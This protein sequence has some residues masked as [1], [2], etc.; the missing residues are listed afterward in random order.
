MASAQVYTNVKLVMDALGLPGDE[1]GLLER[2]REASAHIQ[3]V[4]GAFIPVTGSKNFIGDFDPNSLYGYAFLLDPLIAMTAIT[5]ANGNS[6]PSDSYKFHPVNRAWENG[7]YLRLESNYDEHNLSGRWGLYEEWISSGLSGTL[8]SSSATSLSL[9]NGGILWPGCVIKLES[10]QCLVTAGQG[11]ENSPSPTTA[12]ATV[13]NSLD[14]TDEVI[15]VTNGAEFSG[16]EVIRIDHEDMLIRRIATND[17]IVQRGW[18]NTQRAAHLLAA[19]ISVYRTVTIERGVNG[20]T[21]AAHTSAAISLAKIPTDVAALATQI[22]ALLRGKAQT[23]YTGR[24]GNAEA[25]ESFW[26]NE[27]PRGPIKAVKEAYSW[28]A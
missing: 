12:T 21:A 25:G 4:I 26:I 3:S 6:V 20:T 22:A 13:A 16:G 9:T 18:N 23:G 1:K 27:F 8:A 19:A 10:E 2:C 17:L 15:S 5:D 24:A 7:P 11:G 28:R 14:E